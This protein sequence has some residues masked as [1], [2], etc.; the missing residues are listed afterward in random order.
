MIEYSMSVSSHDLEPDT[1]LLDGE[2]T[3]GEAIVLEG[4]GKDP[5]PFP[6]GT[7]RKIGAGMATLVM[8]IVSTYFVPG[9]EWARPWTKDDPVLFWNIIGREILGEGAQVEAEAESV[10]KAEAVARAVAV[11]EEETPFEDRVIVRPPPADAGDGTPSGPAYQP[12]PDDELEVPQSLEMANPEVLDRFFEK[13]TSTEAGYDG[14]I[15]RVTQW[16]DSVI[17][18]DNVTSTLRAKMQRRFGDAGHGFHLLAKPNNNYRHQGLVFSGGEAWSRCYII[19]KCKSDGHYGLGGT[20]VWSSGGAQSLFRTADKTPFGQKASRFE[21]WYAQHAKGGKI[22]I[23][24]DRG[25][26][27][28]VDTA[29]PEDAPEGAA[30]VD[31]WHVIEMDD[32]PHAI[33]VRAAGGGLVRAY[34]V[35]LERD[36]PGVVWDGMEQLGAFASRMLYFDEDHLRRQLERRQT[37]LVV[38]MF[39]GNDLQL[40]ERRLGEYEQTMKDVLHRFRTNEGGGPPRACLVVSPVDHGYRD[41]G[42]VVGNPMVPKLTAVQRKVALAEGCAFFDTYAAMGGDGAV[43]R[44]RRAKPP[45][46]SGDLAHLTHEG[47][48]V[49][50]HY[51]YLALMETYR[52]YRSRP[53]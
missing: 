28:V 42:R 20:T 32:G 21:L 14:A 17:A 8:L 51:I 12:H 47:Q 6:P 48:R 3:R 50:G 39:G 45:L 37:D 22:R 2:E 15:T 9:L 18:N 16:G 23:T 34:G 35:V 40:G 33:D 43:G 13:L 26:P 31:A 5:G 38:L 19:N 49:L 24:V 52:E 36:V 25:E 4:E 46:I 11:E 7:F 41:A 1:G 10:A 27:V 53:Q 30:L 44:W 29:L